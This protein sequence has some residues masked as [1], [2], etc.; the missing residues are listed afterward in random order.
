MSDKFSATWLSHSS[1]R[2]FINCPRAYYLG[3]VYKD[4]KTGH[5]IQLIS[6]PL[7]L[8]Q[9]VHAVIERLSNLP[10]KERLKTSLIEKFETE[11]KR[12]SGLNGGFFSTDVEERYKARG[13]QML[14]RVMEHPGPINN[15]AVKIDQDLPYYWLSESDELIL[16]GKIDWLEYLEDSD[17]VHIIDFKTSQSKEEEA[18]LQL[19]IYALLVGNT[20]NRVVSK[21]SYWYLDQ[22]D[23]P[24]EQSMPNLSKAHEEILA[25]GKKMRLM[26]KLNN[27][28]C[29]KGEVG[30]RYCQPLEEI[31]AGQAEFVGTGE[32]N[33]DIYVLHPAVAKSSKIL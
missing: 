13:R 31:V 14:N 23:E 11:W 6:P 15:R 30:C 3:N 26:R 2:D 18:S 29:P 8:G 28:K 1:I 12:V 25:I 19:P 17:S 24:T 21:I 33:K 10:V 4:P 9:A 5:K 7:A 32:F 22:A 20:Q 16:C 27:F